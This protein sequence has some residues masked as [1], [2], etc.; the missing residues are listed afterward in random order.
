MVISLHRE[1]S[2]H[3]DGLPDREVKGRLPSQ[4]LDGLVC[5]TLQ[6]V[7]LQRLDRAT[8]P[9]TVPFLVHTHA[10]IS[11]VEQQIDH[12]ETKIV[13]SNLE[14]VRVLDVQ[15]LRGLKK[16]LK[17]R[18]K[19]VWVSQRQND[20]KKAISHNEKI[21]R[22]LI[23][24]NSTDAQERRAQ[25]LEFIKQVEGQFEKDETLRAQAV[26]ADRAAM[27][28][29]GSFFRN[30]EE[31]E[32]HFLENERLRHEAFDRSYS[33]WKTQLQN[34]FEI[35]QTGFARE[36]EELRKQVEEF[37]QEVGEM[38]AMA[39]NVA[40]GT[41]NG[42]S[43]WWRY[44]Y[45]E[46]KA[47]GHVF[48]GEKGEESR[49]AGPDEDDEPTFRKKVNIPVYPCSILD[50]EGP[51]FTDQHN[52]ISGDRS[53][54][55]QAPAHSE[56]PESAIHS[57]EGQTL[58]NNLR[59]PVQDDDNIADHDPMQGVD[60]QPS[61]P[62]DDNQQIPNVP[63]DSE[64]RP[65]CTIA[66][67]RCCMIERFLETLKFAQEAE[68]DRVHLYEAMRARRKRKFR[69]N[70][71]EDY[72]KIKSACIPESAER[73]R[74]FDED[75]RTQEMQFQSLLREDSGRI[76]DVTPWERMNLQVTTGVVGNMGA[77]YQHIL[78]QALD[79]NRVDFS[80]YVDEEMRARRKRQVVRERVLR[81]RAL[82]EAVLQERVLQEGVLGRLKRGLRQ[83]IEKCTEK[84][85]S[86]R[87]N[88]K[89]RVKAKRQP[90]V[91]KRARAMNNAVPAPR[92]PVPADLSRLSTVA[93]FNHDSERDYNAYWD[94]H[95]DAAVDR[96]ERDRVHQHIQQDPRIANEVAP[97]GDPLAVPSDPHVDDGLVAG[98]ELDRWL[99][100]QR[101]L[102]PVP[103]AESPVPDNNYDSRPAGNHDNLVFQGGEMMIDA[104]DAQPEFQDAW[105]NVDEVELQRD[106]EQDETQVPQGM[107]GFGD[108]AEVPV[109][110]SEVL[111]V[112]QPMHEDQVSAE[113]DE[114]QI[115]SFGLPESR[116]YRRIV[117]HNLLRTLVDM[118]LILRWGFIAVLSVFFEMVYEMYNQWQYL[119][120][121]NMQL[122][123]LEE[124][125]EEWRSAIRGQQCE[126]ELARMR[127]DLEVRDLAVEEEE[128]FQRGRGYVATKEDEIRSEVFRETQDMRQDRMEWH[129]TMR[130]REYAQGVQ[131]RVRQIEEWKKHVKAKMNE[132]CLRNIDIAIHDNW[133]RQCFA[134]QF[135]L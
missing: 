118:F 56:F 87:H 16:R 102:V 93:I 84:P 55:A 79:R 68:D 39:V 19:K 103:I 71:R 33:G 26:D 42:G 76:L 101:S 10:R 46:D 65:K 62:S 58:R 99:I 78:D 29:P 30:P 35:Q 66:M 119:G 86:P 4:V 2:L 11:M 75:A 81:E 40:E 128:E 114:P 129:M 134:A 122:R 15:Q 89:T 135:Q 52:L 41:N 111:G 72:E 47:Q 34:A 130:E 60:V 44:P 18:N 113:E 126:F 23:E 106:L 27:V 91:Q 83:I 38:V 92:I 48:L 125:V 133:H 112:E 100:Q 3:L 63:Q 6:E 20:L 120:Y 77:R 90:R 88:I 69:A 25:H 73:D 28:I 97:V 107:D 13:R 17:K 115:Y 9:H 43:S 116:D 110:G 21:L 94:D 37:E 117:T 95:I 59:S 80:R 121:R 49:I 5:T 61:T 70:R 64:E 127:R 31:E 85:S 124:D 74:Q 98:E 54:P 12:L 14:G 45:D 82:R 7:A 36:K 67:A 51:E 22:D 108:D 131:T 132:R 109:Q 96:E 53:A 50:E 105:E 24:F 32:E 123:W 1:S 57:E 8:P 104:H